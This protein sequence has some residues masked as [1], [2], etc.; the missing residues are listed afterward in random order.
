M[1][2]I[3]RSLQRQQPLKE[4]AYQVLRA[5]ILSGELPPGQ[6]LVE[7]Q[8]AKDL[9]VSRT[10]VREALRLLQHEELV[11]TD[12]ENILH[13]ATFSER[14]AAEFYECRIALEQLSVAGACQFVTDSQLQELQRM[15]HQA[16]KL[17]I[18][19]PSQLLNFQ[20]LDLDYRFHRLIAESSQNFQLRSML[21][22]LF[23]KMMLLR[24]QTIQHNRNVLNICTEHQEIYD[25]IAQRNSEAAAI[26]IKKH[27]LA[28]KERVIHEM[29]IQNS[30]SK[31][32]STLEG[33]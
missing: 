2:R 19:K 30:T 32:P 29:M 6:R 10:P 15:I 4:Q 25:T 33:V 18:G 21:D 13:V 23:D 7:S 22:H 5:A 11:T 28:S 14:D 12:T 20:L 1:S 16:E 26:A 8:L 9:Q 3:S 31:T 24:I 17:S 27:L